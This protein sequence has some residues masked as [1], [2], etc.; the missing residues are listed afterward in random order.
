M[1]ITIRDIAREA[2]VSTATA[3]RALRRLHNVDP[4]TIARVQAVADRH[5]YVVSPA[6][7]R[8]AGGRTGSVAA[9]TPYVS[10]WYFATVLSGV[11][12]VLQEA[13]T[14]LLLLVAGDPGRQARTPPVRRLSQRVDGFLVI[15]LDPDSPELGGL[16]ELDAPKVLVGTKW[17]GVPSVSI[18]DERAAR[19]ATQHLVNLGHR[20]IGLIAGRPG[21]SPF[22]AERARKRGFETAVAWP[23]PGSSTLEYGYGDFTVDGGETAMNALL[24]QPHPP[25]AVF[26]MSD[27]MAFGAMRALRLHGLVAGRDVSLVGFDGHDLSGMLDLTTVVQPVAQIGATA[28][29]MLLQEISDASGQKPVEVEIPTRLVVRSS[30]RPPA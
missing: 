19:L 12:Q 2:G 26:C 22:L 1:A 30:S 8:L 5:S 10:R 17:P 14:D 21:R 18:D 11:E 28:A 15:S 7:S 25:T 4:A 3:S 20:R 23:A 29:Q 9:L 24:A 13:E 16:L 27:E 6:A